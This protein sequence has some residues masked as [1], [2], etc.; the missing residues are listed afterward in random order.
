MLSGKGKA[1]GRQRRER[2]SASPVRNEFH[3]KGNAKEELIYLTHI[4]VTELID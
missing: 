3:S 2:F 4:K 1:K